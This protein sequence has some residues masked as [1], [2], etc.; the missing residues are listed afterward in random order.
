[1]TVF[2][3]GQLVLD[4]QFDP[5]YQP[6][7]EDLIQYAQV[8][9]IDPIREPD[10]L[11][12]AYEGLNAPLPADWKPCQD[13]NG[14][15]YYFNFTTGLSI[16]DHPCDV[17][18]RQVVAT[19]RAKRQKLR[20]LSPA[21]S[22][23][24]FSTE[25]PPWSTYS[26]PA[27]SFSSMGNQN[28]NL[29]NTIMY[30][31][32]TLG[33]QSGTR[34][35]LFGH[36]STGKPNMIRS[37]LN[38]PYRPTAESSFVPSQSVDNFAHSNGP[39]ST[40]LPS[41]FNGSVN[42]TSGRVASSH[43]SSTG[44]SSRSCD[45]EEEANV[46]ICIRPK[47]VVSDDSSDEIP[48]YMPN[49][50]QN[51]TPDRLNGIDS[52]P[53]ARANL[54]TPLINHFS[55]PTTGVVQKRPNHQSVHFQLDFGRS[56]RKQLETVRLS[57]G[58][59]CSDDASSESTSTLSILNRKTLTQSKFD[60]NPVGQSEARL[61]QK[62]LDFQN[63]LNAL[64]QD[65]YR[66][67]CQT[68]SDDAH[69]TNGVSGNPVN[70]YQSTSPSN[71]AQQCSADSAR[72]PSTKSSRRMSRP[73]RRSGSTPKTLNDLSNLVRSYSQENCIRSP[74]YDEFMGLRQTDEIQS[75]VAKMN[76]GTTR[77]RRPFEVVDRRK[78]RLSLVN[79]ALPISNA[80]TTKS[81]FLRVHTDTKSQGDL[82][83]SSTYYPQEPLQRAHS[84]ESHLATQH[85]ENFYLPSN[86][87]NEVV[88]DQNSSKIQTILASL[89]QLET[90]L[91][92]VIQLCAQNDGHVSSPNKIIEP[93]ASRPS[94]A[95]E[96]SR[97][98]S[99]GRRYPIDWQKI[100]DRT[101]SSSTPREPR[102]S[103]ASNTDRR[104]EEYR[105]WLIGAKS[106]FEKCTTQQR[107]RNVVY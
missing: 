65:L 82:S 87:L 105:Q 8:I 95:R 43:S 29:I 93:E 91:G 52:D 96:V 76:N 63:Q 81:G 16:W 103:Q 39:N 45:L 24:Q 83:C 47:S 14:D 48:P 32:K 3:N 72:S 6:S 98:V 22:S 30:D 44:A 12:L 1:M 50:S 57:S 35:D 68:Q 67:H 70:Y 58:L 27:V 101:R 34:Q 90:D 89:E 60:A 49:V 7:Q 100:T 79:G 80:E 55:P 51:A 17:H 41:S 9:G 33:H 11:Y 38:M 62:L 97:V 64:S 54:V 37:H 2:E 92:E 28:G 10:L 94:P 15:I 46:Q 53:H 107:S 56:T 31:S 59:G 20:D 106:Q 25:Y 78:R 86:R 18:Y 74:T 5:T 4:E 75:A 99:P 66:S 23:R 84:V 26:Q 77:S 69:R 88:T 71:H 42:H 104:I 73:P 21:L 85:P 61:L 36:P 40:V 13:V 19:E 102:L